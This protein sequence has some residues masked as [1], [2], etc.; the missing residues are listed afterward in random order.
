M[1]KL[2]LIMV[3]C[4]AG[5][6]HAESTK[7]PPI[8]NNSTYANGSAYSGQVSANQ[9][10]L[11]MLGRVESLQ[12]EIQQLRGMVEQQNHEINNLK[13]RQQ[14]IYA[15]MNVRLQQLETGA[16]ISIGTAK[17]AALTTPVKQ[18]N[19]TAPAPVK[20]AQ[21]KPV[22]KVKPVSKA[23]EKAAFEKAYTS[24]RN[25]HFQQAIKLLEQFLQDYPDGSYSDNAHF[26]LGSVYKLVNNIP[27]AKINFQA[28]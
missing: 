27:A 7:L 17:P 14:N 9:P 8:I 24:V 5:M 28:V 25:N 6:V 13:Q 12:T 2:C 21:P 16:G 22:K 1:N 15:D 26:W 4:F 10:M 20:Q 11:E 18:Y 3:L 23:E 19:T